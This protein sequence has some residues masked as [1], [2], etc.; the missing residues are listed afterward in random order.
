M[1]LDQLA[2]RLQQLSEK[3]GNCKVIL[4]TDIFRKKMTVEVSTITVL[5]KRQEIELS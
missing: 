4:A 1:T 5:E 3:H 2:D